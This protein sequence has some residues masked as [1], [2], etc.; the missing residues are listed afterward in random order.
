MIIHLTAMIVCDIMIADFWGCRKYRRSLIDFSKLYYKIGGKYPNNNFRQSN[1]TNF[2]PNL[3]TI[4]EEKMSEQKISRR[5]FL[6]IAATVGAG[7]VLAACAPKPATETGEKPGGEPV[8]KQGVL[9]RYWCGWG[10]EG[11][12]TAW[13]RIQALPAFKEIL[14]NN[15]FEV[16]TSVG[17][18]AMLTAIAGGEPPDTGGNV[19]YLGFMARD[20]LL[21]L[22][23]YLA[24]GTTKQEDFIDG[25][26]PIC[27]YKGVQY[28]I[29]SQEGFLRYGLNF[30][31]KLVEEGGLDP[32]NP[33][34]T[35]D[36]LLEWHIQLTQKDSAGNVTRIGINPF[37][38]M[39]EGM[40]DTDG[41]MAATSWNWQWFD[42]GTGKFNLN[43]PNLVEAFAT[44]KKFIDVVGPDNL[45]ALYNVAGRDTWGGAYNAEAECGLIEGYW[46]PGET[47]HDK[48][49]V[50]ANNRATWLPVPASRRGVKVQ[51]AG[52]HVWTIFKGSKNPDVM[53]KIGELLNTVEPGKILWEL[54]GWLP[55]GKAFLDTVDPAVYPGLD[56]YFKSYKEATEW[57]APARCEIT[58]FVSNEYLNIKDKVNRNEMTPEQAAEELQ[59]RCEEEYKNA[60]FAS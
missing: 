32:E 30:N 53:F 51:G 4:Q 60:G 58:S 15:T 25:I 29:P 11:Y 43:H 33:P 52:G 6:R 57:V 22:T 56:F 10:G 7:S 21:P 54:Q 47:M 36:E 31:K 50:A 16:K 37:A 13:D 26:W 45:A 40:W 44:F 20:I 35:W 48:P 28:G 5:D 1:L 55:S 59:R 42:E 14:G 27:F 49:D 34:Q 19:N 3:Y 9:L 12:T 46:H 38:A 2:L 41:W 23:D 17:E 39:G 24:T 18:E 8:A